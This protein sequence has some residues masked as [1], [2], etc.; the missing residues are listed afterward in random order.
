MYFLF[1]NALPCIAN[2]IP[3]LLYYIVPDSMA[4]LFSPLSAMMFVI[5]V[6]A[7]AELFRRACYPPSVSALFFSCGVL[8]LANYLGSSADYAP[9][10][11]RQASVATMAWALWFLITVSM[12]FELL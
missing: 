6:L 3:I 10:D 4:I 1:Y 5:M 9:L 12:V 8:I 2:Y 11:V 7:Q